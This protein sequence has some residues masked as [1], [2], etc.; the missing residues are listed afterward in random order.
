MLNINIIFPQNI[1]YLNTKSNTTG[2]D[3]TSGFVVCKPKFIFK[4]WFQRMR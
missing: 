4:H 2:D 3:I 1:V